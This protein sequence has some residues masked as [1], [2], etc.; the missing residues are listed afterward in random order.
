MATVVAIMEALASELETTLGTAVPDLHVYPLL[1]TN[2]TPPALDVYPADPFTEKTAYGRG[3]RSLFFTVRARV[4]TADH[5]AGQTVL[6]GMMD[7]SSSSSVVDALEADP[8]LDNTVSDLSVEGPSEYGVFADPSN[9][10][11]LLG[12]TWRVQ[13]IP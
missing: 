9:E 2:P 4:N 11:A 5:T 6:L 7:R 10:G 1:E 13:V 3:S 8:Q 12:C